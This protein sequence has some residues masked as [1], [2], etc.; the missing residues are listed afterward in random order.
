MHAHPNEAVVGPTKTKVRSCI[1]IGDTGLA[2]SRKLT[3]KRPETHCL[4]ASDRLFVTSFDL[5]T[6]SILPDLIKKDKKRESEFVRKILILFFHV[7]ASS[8]YETE[9]KIYVRGFFHP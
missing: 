7:V 5:F 8:R 2:S 1:A 6:Q 3:N 4:V 9:C